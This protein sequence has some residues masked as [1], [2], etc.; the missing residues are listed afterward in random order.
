MAA[1]ELCIPRRLEQNSRGSILPHR[2]ALPGIEIVLGQYQTRQG[3][4]VIRGQE[5][6]RTIPE[7]HPSD[8]PVELGAA[9]HAEKGAP[10]FLHFCSWCRIV[11]KLLLAV[12][13]LITPFP[14]SLQLPTTRGTDSSP[15]RRNVQPLWRSFLAVASA[16]FQWSVTV[17]HPRGCC[18]WTLLAAVSPKAWLQGGL[19]SSRPV[20][21]SRHGE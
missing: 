16:R 7:A 6:S 19:I 18:R 3:S 1:G 5:T 4:S 9:S 21:A 15:V 11:K 17:G 14:F 20:V 8:L 13:A 12:H 10:N 2:V